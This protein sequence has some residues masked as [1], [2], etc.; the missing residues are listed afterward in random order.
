MRPAKSTTVYTKLPEFSS[1]A[2]FPLARYLGV[3]YIVVPGRSRA[4]RARRWAAAASCAGAAGGR[5]HRRRRSAAVDARTPADGA[6]APVHACEAPPADGTAH[7]CSSERWSRPKTEEI[8]ACSEQEVTNESANFVSRLIRVRPY[9][10]VLPYGVGYGW[11]MIV[12]L[13]VRL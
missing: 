5:R 11:I 3:F 10:T 9:C 12:R 7:R 1:L 13:S 4:L 2:G 6:A 8:T